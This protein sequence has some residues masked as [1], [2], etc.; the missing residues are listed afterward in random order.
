[1]NVL[2]CKCKSVKCKVE[3]PTSIVTGQEGHGLV[4]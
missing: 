4:S 3:T 1:M 2:H